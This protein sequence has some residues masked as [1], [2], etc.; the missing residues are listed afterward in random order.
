MRRETVITSLDCRGRSGCLPLL[1]SLRST[2]VVLV[3][4]AAGAVPF[5]GHG[6]VVLGRGGDDVAVAQRQ[7][8][9][10]HVLGRGR[11]PREADPDRLVSPLE[12]TADAGDHDPAA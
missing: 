9:V 1:P 2:S 8:E 6:D 4:P 7:L 11:P 5:A 12:P 10:D 3:L